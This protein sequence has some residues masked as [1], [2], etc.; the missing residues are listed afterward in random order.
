MLWPKA[1]A[2]F[3]K[4][5]N[6]KDAISRKLTFWKTRDLFQWKEQLYVHE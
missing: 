4:L 1:K 3:D 6:N 5:I 2:F